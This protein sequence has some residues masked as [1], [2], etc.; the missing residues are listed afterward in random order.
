MALS[1]AGF[2]A[3]ALAL[4]GCTRRQVPERVEWSVMGTVAAVQAK[5]S[6]DSP[7]GAHTSVAEAL[8]DMSYEVR[9]VF[10]EVESLLNAH[11]QASEIHRLA[12][13]PDD[14]VVKA[15]D[16]KMRPCYETAFMLKEATGGAFNPRWKG[17][18][19]LDLGA[20]A[21]GFAVD[22]AAECVDVQKG[23]SA[24]VDLGGNVKAVRGRWRT[25][26]K[27]PLGAGVAATVDLVD[28]EALATSAK[29]F[30][31]EHIHDGRTGGPATNGVASVTVLCGS[32]MTADGLSTALFV[33]GPDEGRAF[34]GRFAGVARQPLAVLWLMAD[35]SR[36]ALDPD[37]RFK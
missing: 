26:V 9:G 10:T 36:V 34:L 3:V 29:Y 13:L 22:L 24:L 18:D 19:T 16:K 27:N 14:Q 20:I 2:A 15:C 37:A 6:E 17:A 8:S 30:R 11:S 1:T 28:G 5:E 21:K 33:L 4:C 23:I 32:A 31:G 7:P 35:G 25:G 12:A